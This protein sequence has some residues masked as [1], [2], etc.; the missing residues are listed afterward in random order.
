[1]NAL[2]QRAADSRSW[3]DKFQPLHLNLAVATHMS[4]NSLPPFGFPYSCTTISAVM[5]STPFGATDMA[6]CANGAGGGTGGKLET[7]TSTGKTSPS[8]VLKTLSAPSHW[9]GAKCDLL[10]FFVE[11]S[12]SPSNKA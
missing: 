3:P 10:Q 12:S 6:T 9:A 1:M 4:L 7:N 8:T 5:I 2:A 11:G